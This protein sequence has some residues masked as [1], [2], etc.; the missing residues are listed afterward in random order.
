MGFL[1]RRYRKSRYLL[2]W[3]SAN[4][5][6]GW[7]GPCWF[8]ERERSSL[9][10][11]RERRG[12]LINWDTTQ[13]RSDVTQ[14]QRLK[15]WQEKLGKHDKKGARLFQRGRQWGQPVQWSH[16]TCGRTRCRS[17][18][19]TQG[20]TGT[21]HRGW[22][23]LL[24]RL[25]GPSTPLLWNSERRFCTCWPSQREEGKLGTAT[26][27]RPMQSPRKGSHFR[28][29]KRT[30]RRAHHLRAERRCQG[31]ESAMMKLAMMQ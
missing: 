2:C 11:Q 28:R 22:W 18:Q 17:G 27:S 9:G 10:S 8:R 31:H 25:H 1:E 13:S 20:C 16:R 12:S 21:S 30:S 19:N 7:R 23:K 3:S 29:K 5:D 4:G 24:Q 6:T 15:H 26:P 14:S